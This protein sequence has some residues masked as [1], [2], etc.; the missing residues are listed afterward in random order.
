MI[1]IDYQNVTGLKISVANILLQCVNTVT[2]P[3]CIH[4]FR[5]IKTRRRGIAYDWLLSYYPTDGIEIKILHYFVNQPRLT[6]IYLLS[7]SILQMTPL[8][9]QWRREGVTYDE[10]ECH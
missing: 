6:R 10:L 9:K 5:C 2:R 1:I 7:S 8:I 4:G 3:R